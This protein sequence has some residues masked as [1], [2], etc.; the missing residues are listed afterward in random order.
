MASTCMPADKIL[1]KTLKLRKSLYLHSAL[2][3][4]FLLPIGLGFAGSTY[5]KLLV[6]GG[7]IYFLFRSVLDAKWSITIYLLL[8]F[9]LPDTWAFDFGP[10]LP[11]IT[12]RRVFYLITFFSFIIYY[13]RFKGKIKFPMLFRFSIGFLVL[14]YT[15][16]TILSVNI[17]ISIF[18]L[19][20]L[21]I[22][23][24]LLMFIMLRV[25]NNRELAKNG[26]LALCLSA[27][28]LCFFGNFEYISNVNHFT[29]V[30]LSDSQMRVY[31]ATYENTERLG[32]YGRIHS[33]CSH[34]MTFGG[35][36]AI[37]FPIVIAF[38]LMS[39]PVLKKMLFL[40]IA[41]LCI[42]GVFFSLARSSVIALFVGIVV[43]L[44][45]MAIKVKI[46]Y[47]LFILSFS[48]ILLIALISFYDPTR[49]I[50][51]SSI[52]PWKQPTEMGGSSLEL[53]IE[54]LRN[55]L[56]YSNKKPVFGYGPGSGWIDRTKAFKKEL[57]RGLEN[58]WM[59]NLLEIGW[60][61]L[62]SLFFFLF[63]VFILLRK[64]YYC[65]KGYTENLL[66]IGGISSFIAFLVFSMATGAMG[67][68]N[69][70]FILL[71]LVLGSTSL[72][73]KNKSIYKKRDSIN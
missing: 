5:L 9:L 46:K 55:T 65:S 48:I 12:L 34:P 68:F 24:I 33:L 59:L 16:S 26:L 52:K 53:R 11:L 50:I 10:S 15:I 64:S 72:I 29:Q 6:L 37:I 14:S 2:I 35:F 19:F 44:I 20:H 18:R 60:V 54:Q 39:K 36:L 67:T 42:E 22:E 28:I 43:F 1:V 71:P 31:W 13:R 49:I 70:V 73:D 40:I 30:S 3:I 7:I 27:L 62:I 56:E 25:L 58:I 4:I 47:V 51:T 38:A 66:A 32:I 8:F 69:L 21:F 23:Q 41:F 63:Q 17:Q 45:F 57:V 61:G